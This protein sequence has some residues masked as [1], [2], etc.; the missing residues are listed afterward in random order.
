M[1]LTCTYIATTLELGE[2]YITVQSCTRPQLGGYLLAPARDVEPYI[3]VHISR[4]S[5]RRYTE[6]QGRRSDAKKWGVGNNGEKGIRNVS[7]QECIC[8]NG[9]GECNIKQSTSNRVDDDGEK[10]RELA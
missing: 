3:V 4:T 6:R 1:S 8:M 5:Q 9:S 10:G 7:Y 2:Q